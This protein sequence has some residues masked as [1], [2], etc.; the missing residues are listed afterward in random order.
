MAAFRLQTIFVKATFRLEEIHSQKNLDCCKSQIHIAV[1]LC[2]VTVFPTI[3]CLCIFLF[4]LLPRIQAKR[5][6][7]YA[8][9]YFISV[10][11]N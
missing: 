10:L 9:A 7:N 1:L 4:Q 6:R 5:E 2:N 11:V 8:K 3:K